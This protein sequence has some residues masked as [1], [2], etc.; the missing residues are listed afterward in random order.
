MQPPRVPDSQ[1]LFCRGALRRFGC[2]S[3]RTTPRAR[4]TCPEAR[5][6]SVGLRNRAGRG[7]PG[8]THRW[9]SPSRGGMSANPV[10]TRARASRPSRHE[11]APGVRW[12]GSSP[13]T[14][15]A[16]GSEVPLPNRL[17]TRT[18]R[19][20]STPPDRHSVQRPRSGRS[21]AK[22]GRAP[23]QP[24]RAVAGFPGVARARRRG[25]RRCVKAD[26]RS[27]SDA[28]GTAET[29]GTPTCSGTL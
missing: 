16:S 18:T 20:D 26:G 3:I 11:R 6:R 29:P 8:G 15:S 17:A 22:S 25:G 14:R 12:A 9:P 1:R 19:G 7:C 4:H 23:C 27:Q 28:M 13:A 2:S 5:A 21:A 10:A 24:T